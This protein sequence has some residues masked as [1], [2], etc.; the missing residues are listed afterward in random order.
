MC[1]YIW[2]IIY[3]TILLKKWVCCFSSC[4]SSILSRF[5]VLRC[6]FDCSP[7]L[8]SLFMFAS[9]FRCLYFL[10]KNC[11]IL[12]WRVTHYAF[13]TG[14]REWH[15]VLSFKFQ[16]VLHFREWHYVLSSNH[17][18]RFSTGYVT[19]CCPWRTWQKAW[20]QIRQ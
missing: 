7:Y 12:L 6:I 15:Y 2:S 17:N 8:F 14:T 18:S 13:I 3:K 5:H 20:S 9:I 4:D 11:T 10:G 19:K 1:W 16:G